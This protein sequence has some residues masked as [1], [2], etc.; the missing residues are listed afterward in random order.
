[1]WI[2]DKTSIQKL[3]CEKADMQMN[4]YILIGS[5]LVSMRT[6]SSYLLAHELYAL[7]I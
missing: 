1:M 7:Y 2:F 4:M 5:G 6:M 3:W